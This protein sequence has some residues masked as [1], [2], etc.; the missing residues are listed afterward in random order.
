MPEQREKSRAELYITLFLLAFVG[1]VAANVGLRSEREVEPLSSATSSLSEHD[2]LARLSSSKWFLAGALATLIISS[3]LL[4]F[5]SIAKL[6]GRP[7]VPQAPRNE[8][9]WNIWAIVKSIVIFIFLYSTA[10]WTI[11][12][13]GKRLPMLREHLAI[14][15]LTDGGLKALVCFWIYIMLRREYGAH[16]SNMGIRLPGIGKALLYAFLGYISI[17][18]VVYVAGLAWSSLGEHL[19]I[20]EKVNPVVTLLLTERSR[21]VILTTLFM[22]VVL[23]PLTEE[24]YFR[25]LTFCALRKSFGFWASA[26]ISSLYFALIHLNFYSVV[27]IFILGVFL[28]YIYERT[29]SFASAVFVHALHNGIQVSLFLSVRQV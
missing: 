18:C 27:P 15:L 17:L 5:A 3:L 6:S 13:L 12:F 2:A 22:V 29:Q 28:A 4:T 23:A 25:V 8:V 1:L 16:L 14:R 24:F 19:A 11:Y 26:A 20:K 21:S 9:T 7:P 10:L